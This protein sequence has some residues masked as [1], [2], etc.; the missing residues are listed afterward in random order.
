MGFFKSLLQDELGA[1]SSKRI[2][3]LICVLCLNTSLIINT[4]SPKEHQPSA[5]IINAVSLLAFGC[6]GLTTFDKYTKMKSNIKEAN[7]EG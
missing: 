6:L 5:T 2:A 1:I 7:K 4:I 3:G